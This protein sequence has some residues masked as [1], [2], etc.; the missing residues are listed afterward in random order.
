MIL[1]DDFPWSVFG[2][3]G[4]HGQAQTHLQ[5][6]TR[7]IDHGMNPQEAIE[8]PRWIAGPDAGND[9]AHLLRVEPGLGDEVVEQLRDLGHEVRVT[10]QWSSAMGHAQAIRIDRDNG[11]LIGGADP[12]ANGYA[13]G[14]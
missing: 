4:G 14:W 8:A 11:V 13:L 5:L 7:L 10:E 9:P 2:C 6:V 12:R 1:K 3:M